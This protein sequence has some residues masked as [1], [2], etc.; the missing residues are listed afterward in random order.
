MT[1]ETHR[2]LEQEFGLPFHVIQEIGEARRTDDLHANGFG[3]M[4]VYQDS[5]V[6]KCAVYAKHGLDYTQGEAIGWA[7]ICD[8]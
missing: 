3:S 5:P 7:Y 8:C 2:A 6:S 4:K 1:N